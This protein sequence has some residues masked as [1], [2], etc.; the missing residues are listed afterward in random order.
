M[1]HSCGLS[2]RVLLSTIFEHDNCKK[3]RICFYGDPQGQND[4]TSKT[5]QISRH[6]NNKALM[7]ERI[8][9]F[10]PYDRIPQIE[11]F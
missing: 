10:N 6:F 9:P 1:G 5:Y 3:I 4:Y 7:R 2:D 8:I 11:T